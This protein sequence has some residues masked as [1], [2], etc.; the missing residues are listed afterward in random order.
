MDA[1]EDFEYYEAARLALNDFKLNVCMIDFLQLLSET[2]K[3]RSKAY[4]LYGAP[5][6]YKTSFVM[7]ALRKCGLCVCFAETSGNCGLHT[8]VDTTARLLQYT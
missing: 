3:V 5:Q 6:T 1:A 2:P 8:D 4:Y 7:Y